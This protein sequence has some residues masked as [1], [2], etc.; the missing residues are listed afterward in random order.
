MQSCYY[1]RRFGNIYAFFLGFSKLKW[2]TKFRMKEERLKNLFKYKSLK[3]MRIVT[4]EKV[5]P[6]KT[7]LIWINKWRHRKIHPVSDPR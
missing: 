4:P 2:L 3:S 7:T 1:G 6:Q 5:L